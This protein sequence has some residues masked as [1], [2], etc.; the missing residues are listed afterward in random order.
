M[1]LNSGLSACTRP[2]VELTRTTQ[3]PS[4]WKD[5]IIFPWHGL[6]HALSAYARRQRS[7]GQTGQKQKVTN[8]SAASRTVKCRVMSLTGRHKM[9]STSDTIS[10]AYIRAGSRLYC[11]VGCNTLA[12][13]S[14]QR[15]CG[16]ALGEVGSSGS[17]PDRD[18][19]CISM[20]PMTGFV[21]SPLKHRL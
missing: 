21:S 8:Y 14:L 17:G 5:Q 6:E 18:R 13:H 20:D 19:A 16:T 4:S 2:I 1:Q 15:A 11:T 10:A 9:Q 7:H 3:V 12:N